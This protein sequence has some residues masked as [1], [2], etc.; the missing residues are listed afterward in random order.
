[1]LESFENSLIFDC[2][3]T[4]KRYLTEI[5]F[6]AHSSYILTDHS[7]LTGGLYFL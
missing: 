7:P 1:M 6:I 4:M 3:S 2:V 5:T